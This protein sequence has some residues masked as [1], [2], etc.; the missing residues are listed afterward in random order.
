MPAP[1]LLELHLG[2]WRVALAPERGAVLTALEH[3]RRAVLE[4]LDGRDPV[5][6][7]AGGFWMLPWTNRLDHGRFRRGG[8][9]FHL[10]ISHPDE[11]NAL[12]GLA[13][14]RPWAV[15]EAGA[16]RAVLTQRLRFEPFDYLARLEVSLSGAGLALRLRLEN[17]G[18][19]PCPMGIGWHPWFARPPGCAVRFKAGHRMVK[20]ERNLPVGAEPSAGIDAPVSD[21]LGFDGHFSE[22]DGVAVLHRPDLELTLRASGDWARNLQVFAPGDHRSVIC[23]EP[24]SHVPNVINTPALEPYGAMRVLAAGEAMEGEVLLEVR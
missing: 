11:A 15:E 23:L 24:V 18:V 5:R 6:N 9:E 16:T 20:G 10:P 4:P 3:R 2:D 17:T 12:H 13:R 22:W 1:A 7:S 14:N 21:F 19:E 8:Q